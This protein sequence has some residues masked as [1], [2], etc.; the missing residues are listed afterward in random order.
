MCGHCC[1]G[2]YYHHFATSGGNRERPSPLIKHQIRQL[3]FFCLIYEDDQTCHENTPMD[4]RMFTILC[5]LLRT[6]GGLRP[7]KY[8]DVEEIVAIFLH[9]VA[10]EV[11]NR[12]MKC[13]FARS[14]ETVS[15]HFNIVLN[16]IL[17]LY[18]VL[19]RRPEPVIENCTDDRW[20]W[21]QVKAS[22]FFY[23]IVWG[24]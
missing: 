5:H 21:F 16:A 7:T 10:H 24:F 6:T 15:R 19:L 11:K 18:E 14:G 17:R 23:G 20:R 13:Q 22:C 12:V 3:N 9:I 4:R 1:N 2:K 8:V